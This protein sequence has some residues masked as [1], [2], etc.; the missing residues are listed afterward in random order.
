MNRDGT[1]RYKRR[2]M[3]LVGALALVITTMNPV[4]AVPDPSGFLT[5]NDAYITLDPGLP[6]GAS[7]LPILSVGDEVG[8]EL[9]E[10]LPDGLGLK[11]GPTDHTVE[12]FVAHEQTTVPFFGSRDF[13]AASVT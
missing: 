3:V 11:P 2:V 9:F 5:Q 12:V 7:V 4:V 13:Q 8:G 10:G 6:S 1:N